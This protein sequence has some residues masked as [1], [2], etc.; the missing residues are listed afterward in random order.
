MLAGDFSEIA[1]R[2]DAQSCRKPLE[3][4]GD[5][6]GCQHDPKQ[7][8]AVPGSSLEVRGEIAGV[9]VRDGSNNSR[10][11]EQQ[12]GPDAGAAPCQDL[13]DALRSSFGHPQTCGWRT[14]RKNPLA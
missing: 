8:V 10:A 11:G 13:V 3:Q 4:H 2:D 9:H 14:H 1:V 7:R 12:R 5:D 6:I